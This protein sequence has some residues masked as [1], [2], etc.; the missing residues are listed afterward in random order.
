MFL[1]IAIQSKSNLNKI[2]YAILFSYTNK[3]KQTK[4][5]FSMSK[6]LS[7]N[8]QLETKPVIKVIDF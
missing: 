3:K 6:N 8:L 2:L 4:Y 1:K 5:S 7:T